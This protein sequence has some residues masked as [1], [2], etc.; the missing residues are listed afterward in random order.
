LRWSSASRFSFSVFEGVGFGVNSVHRIAPPISVSG[1]RPNNFLEF[2]EIVSRRF[3]GEFVEEIL[4]KPKAKIFGDVNRRYKSFGDKQLKLSKAVLEVAFALSHISISKFLIVI[5]EIGFE[6]MGGDKAG[7][8][9]LPFELQFGFPGVDKDQGFLIM[10]SLY[11]ILGAGIDENTRC[12]SL[13]IASTVFD[14]E[15]GSVPL[16]V[17]SLHDVHNGACCKVMK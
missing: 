16:T 9:S 15:I 4:A 3:S 13:T 14:G 6:L 12:H 2:A 7:A 8:D 11:L 5:E 1:G 17:L 10:I